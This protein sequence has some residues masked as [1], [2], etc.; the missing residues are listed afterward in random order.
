MNNR[1]LF[2]KQEFEILG[3]SLKVKKSNL[4]DSSE[5]EISFEQIHNKKKV[6]T[7]TNNN[8][9][10]IAF[11]L[12]VIGL[13]FQL[14]PNTEVSITILIFAAIFLG[15]ALVS[16]QKVITIPTYS[17]ETIELFFNRRTKANLLDF[18]DRIIA[19]SNS[20]LLNK[21]GKVDR[22][23]PLEGQLANINFLRDREIITDEEYER[24]KNNLLGRDN[25]STLGFTH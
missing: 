13:L 18:S 17:G 19:A 6:Q 16:R 4:L 3:S 25:K 15:C 8:L 21:Y 24:L 10:V 1:K 9:L 12:L 23:L 22:A 11:T 20:F 2:K 14:G 5:Y 7:T